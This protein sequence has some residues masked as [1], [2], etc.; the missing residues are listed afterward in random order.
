MGSGCTCICNIFLCRSVSTTGSACCVV[1]KGGFRLRLST[2]RSLGGHLTSWG[3]HRCLKVGGSFVGQ[4]LGL[5][6]S[7][8]NPTGHIFVTLQTDGVICDRRIFYSCSP[9]DHAVLVEVQSCL[10]CLRVS[11]S[12][13]VILGENVTAIIPQKV[14]CAGHEL[15]QV[16]GIHAACFRV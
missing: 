11:V 2:G 8:N 10:M 6:R 13:F 1:S 7:C 3:N 9:S 4:L 12:I 16:T 14:F 15:V 5:T